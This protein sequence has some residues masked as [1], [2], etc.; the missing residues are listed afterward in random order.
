MDEALQII[1]Y[2]PQSF[3]NEKEQEY[4]VF[5]WDSFECN[6]QNEKYQFALLPFHM[7]YM[8]F[9]YFSVWQIK[10]TRPDDFQKAL[11]GFSKEDEKRLL[12]ASTPF[13][14]WTINESRIFRFL[15]LIG[16]ENGHIGQFAKL[17]KQR[18]DIAHSNGN[19][20]FNN[21]ES[22]DDQISEVLTQIET[23]QDHM[24]KVIHSCFTTFLTEGYD[25]E[26]REYT[27]TSDQIREW[28]IQE[29]FFSH[30]DID[31]CLAFNINQLNDHPHFDAIV[32]LFDAFV[33]EYQEES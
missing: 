21:Q 27:D 22:A 31:M 17:V 1:E 8:S 28:L 24:K 14:F 5:L 3:E 10:R 32:E 13:L 6:Y 20:F 26:E 18:N 30:K 11:V 12:D 15:K 9:V 16:C 19:I 7:L 29:N 25:P 23:I 2:L 4:I 33:A